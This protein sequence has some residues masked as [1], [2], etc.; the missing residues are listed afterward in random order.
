MKTTVDYFQEKNWRREKA[1][2]EADQVTYILNECDIPF[3]SGSIA[4]KIARAELK[5]NGFYA[6]VQDGKKIFIQYC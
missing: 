5:F 6:F 1:K 4:F 3:P 2:S